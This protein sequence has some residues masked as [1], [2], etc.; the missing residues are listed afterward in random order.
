MAGRATA[1]LR[2]RLLHHDDD[3]AVRVALAREDGIQ[4][5]AEVLESFRLEEFT[6]RDGATARP[7]FSAGVAEY[8]RDGSDLDE[9]YTAA[10]AALYLAKAEGRDRLVPAGREP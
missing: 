2:G 10:D 9:L 1:R 5:L 6:G 7:S 4:R 8:P 3:V